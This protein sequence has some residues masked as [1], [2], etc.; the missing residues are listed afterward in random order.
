MQKFRKR[1]RKA[2]TE[3]GD[4]GFLLRAA[5]DEGRMDGR[6][7]GDGRDGVCGLIFWRGERKRRRRR[8]RR[9]GERERDAIKGVSSVSAPKWVRI[10]FPCSRFGKRSAGKS[11]K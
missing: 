11:S 1:E 6:G 5:K 9:R 2:T 7:M 8:R 3:S 10:F 4:G